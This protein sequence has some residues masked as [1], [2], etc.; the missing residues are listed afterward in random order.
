VADDGAL[1]LD[2][3]GETTR[4]T[5]VE[6]LLFRREPGGEGDGRDERIA[7]GE[8]DGAVRYLFRGGSPTAFARVGFRE[9]TSTHLLA[10]GAALAGV[11]DGW[12]L[13]SPDRDE[14][15]SRR[16]WLASLRDDRERLSRAAVHGASTGFVA[17]L[18]ATFV[19]LSVA[20]FGVL[21]SPSLPFRAAF[22]LPL[23]GAVAAAASAVLAV[24]R[25]R[26]DE[27]SLRGRVHYGFVAA[28][29]VA[30]TAF[31]WRWNLLFPP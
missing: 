27:R 12:L 4:W 31:L 1:V 28:A 19:H 22:A 8:A 16:E 11:A 18:A 21:S 2:G 23:A 13:W 29:T 15:E 7:F 30:M 6:P 17:F 25:W 3:G 26:D 14:G 20:P 10:G 24:D 5:E 9:S